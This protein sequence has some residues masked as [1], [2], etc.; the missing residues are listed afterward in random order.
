MERKFI[1]WLERFPTLESLAASTQRDVLLA[2][3]GMGYNRRALLLHKTATELVVKF[4]GVIPGDPEILITLP[5]IGRYTSHAIA[6][7]AFARRVP[8]VD[9][10]IRRVIS[11][12][13]ER[14]PFKNSLIDE[15]TVWRLAGEYLPKRKVAQWNQALMDFG[16]TVCTTV[17]PSC[18][19]CPVTDLCASSGN[20]K[21]SRTNTRKSQ[22]IPR[23]IYRGKIIEFLR[24]RTPTHSAT[25]SQIGFQI[26]PGFSEEHHLWLQDILATLQR[27]SMIVTFFRKKTVDVSRDSFPLAS[28]K[29]SLV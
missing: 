21:K 14:Q 27:D 8:L 26:K 1:E 12:L 10:N 5:G 29:I 22:P 25:F 13:A 15:N 24:G 20:M 3:S 19:E 16:A 18:P 9:V 6:S 23:R 11:R 2:W 7:F 28:L 17:N 4:G